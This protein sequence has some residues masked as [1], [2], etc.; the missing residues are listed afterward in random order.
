M[1]PV[2]SDRELNNGVD[3]KSFYTDWDGEYK[4]SR[5]ALHR[6]L[7][8]QGLDGHASQSQPHLT[9][10]SGGAGAGKSDAARKAQGAGGDCLYVNTDEM[11]ARLPEF[12]L[13]EG[14]DN[15]GL[16][17]EEAGDI[18]DQLLAEAVASR[19]NVI[20]DA[21]GS[22]WVAAYLTEIET[23]GYQ[24]TIAYTHRPVD[25][26]KAAAKYRA[27]NASNAADR[28]VV[29][30]DVID[31]SHRKAREGF[32]LMAGVSGREVIVYDKTGK[33]RGAEA[34]VIYHRSSTGEVLVRLDGQI[35]R[36]TVGAEPEIDETI[37]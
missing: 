14:T 2:W 12:A 26:A 35:R 15:A 5:R 19:L 16:L 7:I 18:R 34:D 29:P 25:E 17:Q 3:T 22:P 9:L 37:F 4:D 30:N 24:V 8:E 23:K 21:P 31:A 10:T 20:W 36:F 13:V 33:D 11:R 1:E 28:R 27:A 32:E 6:E